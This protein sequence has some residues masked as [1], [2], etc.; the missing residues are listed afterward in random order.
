MSTGPQSE[1]VQPTLRYTVH[2]LSPSQGGLPQWVRLSKWLELN[3]LKDRRGKACLCS[4]ITLLPRALAASK[5]SVRFFNARSQ[6]VVK[7][8][9]TFADDRVLSSARI[10]EY[11]SA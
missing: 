1:T 3:E 6:Q 2:Y 7:A 4:N 8:G 5:A 9:N 10:L 11:L